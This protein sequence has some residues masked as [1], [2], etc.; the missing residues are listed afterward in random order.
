MDAR[1]F[2]EVPL[3]HAGHHVKGEF[4]DTCR[5]VDGA[6]GT[7]KTVGIAAEKVVVLFQPVKADGK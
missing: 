5:H 7:L 4:L 1:E 6:H 2:R 3:V